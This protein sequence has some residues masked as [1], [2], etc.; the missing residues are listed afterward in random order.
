[1]MAAQLC[2]AIDQLERRFSVVTEAF[3]AIKEHVCQ[4]RA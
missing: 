3:S 2:A 1:M 4:V